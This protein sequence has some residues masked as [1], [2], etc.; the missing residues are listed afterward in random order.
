MAKEQTLIRD[1]TVGNPMKMLLR[2]SFPFILANLL[3]Q[4]YNI[5]DMVI[6]GQ[7][8]GTA[9]LSA[10]SAGGEIAMLFLFIA[11]G[12]SSAGQIIVSQHIGKGDTA[13][14]GKTVGTL[15]AFLILLGAVFTVLSLCICDWLL[16][17]LN[18]PEEAFAYAHDYGFV[19]F[20]GMIPVFGYNTVSA[21]LRGMG[22]SKHPF[23]FV[24]FSAV[25]N[26]ILD[27]LF[28]GLFDLRWKCMGAALATVISQSAAFVISVAFL[29]R[30]REQLGFEFKLRSLRMDKMELAAIVKLGLPLSVQNAAV[31]ISMLFINSYINAFGV[32][33]SAATAVG[34][35]IMMLATI[36]TVALNTAGNSVIAQNFAAGKIKRVS[37][38]TGCILILSLVF[39]GV[40]AVIFLLFPEQVFGLFDTD[41]EV[42][43]MS[44][45]YAPIGVIGLL[46]FATRC[47]ALAFINGIGNSKLSFI[48][49]LI[50]AT[51]ARIGLALLFGISMGM[52]ISGFWL[53]NV[54]AGNVIGVIG[55]LYYLPGK[56]KHRKTLV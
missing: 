51:V 15:F 4:V 28:V 11:I 36:V 47:P 45:V 17:T 30:H 8:V 19:Y 24:A 9:G 34:N 25:A 21:I 22:D 13:A 38:T 32:V 10:A 31:S 44:H 42:L 37:Q 18:V 40:L 35:K 53:G 55:L 12:F 50:D 27:L 20:I 41:P 29:V 16:R 23:M 46:G 49:G 26:I 7:F 56:W 14:V 33:A 3:Q 52:G 2:F 1:L 39:C 54:L 6:V 48:S 43:A 5:A